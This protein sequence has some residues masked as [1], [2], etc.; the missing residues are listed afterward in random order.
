M[1]AN[2]VASLINVP[3]KTVA[4]WLTVAKQMGLVRSEY[5]G[6]WLPN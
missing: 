6:G 1:S 5:R 3:K 4:R 2:D